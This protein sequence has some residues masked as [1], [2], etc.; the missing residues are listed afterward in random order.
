MID[1]VIDQ[2]KAAAVRDYLQTAFVGCRIE[3]WY[4]PELKALCFRVSDQGSTYHAVVSHEFLD[5]HDALVIGPKLGRFT[6]AEH[7][8]DLPSEQI[9]V[10]NGGLKLDY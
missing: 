4:D 1:K 10:T 2:E 8:R 7:L 3:E 5:D 6:L 9:I